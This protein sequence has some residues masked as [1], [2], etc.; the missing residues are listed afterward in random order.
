MNEEE[1]KAQEELQASIVAIGAQTASN[2][3]LEL[4]RLANAPYD[5]ELPVPEV[6]S[7]IFNVASVEPGEDFEYFTQDP[8]TKVVYTVSNGSVTQT[9]VSPDSENDLSFSSYDSAE[10]YVYL[11]DLLDGKYDPIAVKADAQQEVLDRVEIKAVCDLLIAGAVAQSNTYA[12]DSGDTAIT[13]SK[14]V[15]MVRSVAKYGTKVVLITGANVTTDVMMMD[16]VYNKQ[17]EV[18]L[19]KLGISKHIALEAFQYTH[20]G[21]KTILDADKAI[22]VAVA[23]S[24][25]N[26]PGYFVRRKMTGKVLGADVGN[27]E[28]LVFQR[29]PIVNV[30]ASAK[31]AVTI[32]TYERFGA[33]LVNAYTCAVFNNDTSYA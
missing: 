25:N 31:S 30:G 22:V 1:M 19:A 15:D 8:E 27:K 4:A 13:P 2:P 12:W 28:R 16:F 29:G 18:T 3:G 21:T 6:I 11:D 7:E 26:K 20:S 10:D 24:K 17:R 23:D 33:V 9:N 32:V 14:L 5:A